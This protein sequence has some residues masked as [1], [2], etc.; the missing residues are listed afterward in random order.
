[1]AKQN[2]IIPEWR[3]ALKELYA[4]FQQTISL[5]DLRKVLMLRR[6]IN[7]GAV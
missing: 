7:S 3:K 2:G 6:Q 4:N 5:V 1:M